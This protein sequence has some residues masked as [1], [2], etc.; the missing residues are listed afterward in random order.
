M[1]VE[2]P[3][4]QF[5]EQIVATQPR[6][7]LIRRRRVFAHHEQQRLFAALGP[8]L[9]ALQPALI[10]QFQMRLIAIRGVVCRLLNEVACAPDDRCLDDA[11]IHRLAQRRVADDVLEVVGLVILRRRAETRR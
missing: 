10:T 8:F 9:I 5:L 7:D 4:V 3:S 6:G 11:R 1:Q 2:R